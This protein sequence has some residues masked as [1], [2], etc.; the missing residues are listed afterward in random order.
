MNSKRTSFTALDRFVG[1]NDSTPMDPRTYM[2]KQARGIA[3]GIAW[4][5]Q[6]FTDARISPGAL[7]DV[8]VDIARERLKAGAPGQ[9]ELEITKRGNLIVF[10]PRKDEDEPRFRLN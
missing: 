8:A 6:T 7:V 1:A 3:G 10:R 2:Q 9:P 5:Q 4:T